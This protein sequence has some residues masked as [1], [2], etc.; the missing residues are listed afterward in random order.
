MLVQ[1]FTTNDHFFYLYSLCFRV[2]SCNLVL[3]QI[4][5]TDCAGICIK[6]D[7]VILQPEDGHKKSV[8]KRRNPSS[9]ESLDSS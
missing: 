7:N 2:K 5:S 6:R 8:M 1:T 4:D 9:L 3:K